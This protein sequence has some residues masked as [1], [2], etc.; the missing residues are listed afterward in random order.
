MTTKIKKLTQA[1]QKF[2][3]MLLDRLRSDC[4]YYL[5][6]GRNL[7]GITPIAHVEEMIRLYD[8]LVVKPVWLTPVELDSLAYKVAK[9]NYKAKEKE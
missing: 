7:W 8:V 4:Y 5:S 1:E 9:I 3:Y 6:H 2:E